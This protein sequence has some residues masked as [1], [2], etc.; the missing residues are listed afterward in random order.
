M[1]DTPTFVTDKIT[2]RLE[3]LLFITEQ[4][5]KWSKHWIWRNNVLVFEAYSENL[6]IVAFDIY[7]E[8]EK[9]TINISVRGMQYFPIL[10]RALS[11]ISKDIE[12]LPNKKGYIFKTVTGTEENVILRKIARLLI[13]TCIK[14]DLAAH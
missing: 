5:V 6:G 13:S 4:Y 11:E 2:E 9:W 14:L 12:I 10:T 1:N 3:K 7:P 8:K